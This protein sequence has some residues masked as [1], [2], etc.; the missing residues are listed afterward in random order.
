MLF[1]AIKEKLLTGPESCS[2]ILKHPK[3]VCASVNTAAVLIQD[4]IN[5]VG[6][7]KPGQPER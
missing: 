1:D 7:D 4:T 6:S 3:K 2:V 5:S